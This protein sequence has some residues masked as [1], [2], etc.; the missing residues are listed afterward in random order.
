MKYFAGIA[1]ALSLTF[2]FAAC[3]TTKISKPDST[4]IE[5]APQKE[6]TINLPDLLRQLEKGAEE[7][8]PPVVVDCSNVLE[9][10]VAEM[11][12][13][14]IDEA[15]YGRVDAWIKAAEKAGAKHLL[16]VIDSM[17]GGVEAG[18]L[19]S[20]ALEE[21]KIPVHCLVD[22][23]AMSMA[24]YVLQSCDTRMMTKR[25]RLMVHEPYMMFSGQ[26]RIN[27][28]TLNNWN[29]D[30]VSVINNYLTQV[31]SRSNMTVEQVMEKISNGRNWYMT[32]K[33]AQDCGFIDRT[34]TSRQAVLTSLRAWGQLPK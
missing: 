18:E 13:G 14:T 11:K 23:S 24:M 10:C 6:I 25:A 19:I 27:T 2:G 21:T 3:A 30:L 33:E 34:A 8:L 12:L 9:K 5:P 20:Q 16:L 7:E 26:T 28:T 4:Q 22:T 17:G 31:T 15:S 1:L 32:W 29:S